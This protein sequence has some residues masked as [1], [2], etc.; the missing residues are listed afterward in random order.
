MNKQ[1]IYKQLFSEDWPTNEELFTYANNRHGYGGDDGYY[2]VSYSS[3]RDDYQREV[4]G[5]YIPDGYLEVNY[6]D[7]E[8]R[9]LQV[10]ETEYLSELKNYLLSSGNEYLAKKI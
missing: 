1:Q 4:E 5:E 10:L 6:W 8:H 2:G 7:G 3:D 9:E